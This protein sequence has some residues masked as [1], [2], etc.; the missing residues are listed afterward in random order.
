MNWVEDDGGRADAGFRG[1]AGDCV[2]RA[3]AIASGLPYAEVY[4]ALAAANQSHGGPRSAREGIRPQAMRDYFAALGW[5]W[6]AT[7]GIG[8]GCRVHL[9]DGELPAGSL[10]VRLS[11]HVTAVV[12]GVIRDTYDPSR[13]G[14]RCVYGFWTVT[15]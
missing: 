15:P 2:C 4:A 9:V 11:R 6:T 13:D 8:T 10:V 14:S 12:D 5:A 1:E 3:A 7:M